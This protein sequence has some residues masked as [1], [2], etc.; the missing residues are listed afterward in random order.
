M[1]WK[2]GGVR[3]NY[4][5]KGW[6]VEGLGWGYS[7]LQWS[8]AADP[9]FLRRGTNPRGGGDVNLLFSIIFV[10]KSMNMKKKW[11]EGGS[12]HPSHQIDPQMG[13]L[14]TSTFISIIRLFPKTSVVVNLTVF[15]NK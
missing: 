10:E 14:V 3:L 7:Y 4:Q 13:L 15:I 6:R 2:G 12:T 11:T 5:K 8:S 1:C 9:G